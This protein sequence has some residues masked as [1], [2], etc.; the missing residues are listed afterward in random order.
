MEPVYKEMVCKANA[1]DFLKER[2]DFNNLYSIIWA[3]NYAGFTL[4]PFT[5][6]F[7]LVC[8]TR[9]TYSS[10]VKDYDVAFIIENSD[11]SH[12]I[13]NKIKTLWKDIKTDDENENDTIA[14]LILGIMRLEDADCI[15][16]HPNY[17]AI[18]E[19]L[20]SPHHYD[21][22][23]RRSKRASL[24]EIQPCPGLEINIKNVNV[25]VNTTSCNTLTEI[26]DIYYL[27]EKRTCVYEP[28]GQFKYK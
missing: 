11:I 4:N 2:D 24:L 20:C 23:T 25:N 26:P 12:K 27:L 15:N 14:A 13:I 18:H 10:G 9:S 7:E 6:N 16:F 28:E 5:D 8:W 3:Y 1:A 17:L 22:G 19:A 21:I